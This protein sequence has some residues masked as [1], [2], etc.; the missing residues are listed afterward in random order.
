MNTTGQHQQWFSN[1]DVAERYGVS[2][3]TVRKWRHDR[4]GP[5]GVVFGRHVRYSL[6][7]LERW[8]REKAAK[9]IQ[10]TA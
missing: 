6:V 9:Q 5:T 2:V 8:E 1:E 7:E 4:S 10:R 3:A